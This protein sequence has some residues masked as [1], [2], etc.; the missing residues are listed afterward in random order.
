MKKMS[1]ENK[2]ILVIEDEPAIGELCRRVLSS[3]GFKVDIVVNG[4]AAQGMIAKRKYALFLLDIRMPVMTGKELYEWLQEENPQLA[5][6]VIFTTGSVVSGATQIFLKQTG[7][8]SLPKPFTPDELKSAVIKAL[9]QIQSKN[10]GRTG[11]H[12]NR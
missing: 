3:E 7:R 10:D 8:P 6:R 9:E 12:I 5:S 4:K 1:I 2:K 11:Q